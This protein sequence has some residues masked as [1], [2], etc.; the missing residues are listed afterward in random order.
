MHEARP[1]FYQKTRRPIR[2]SHPRVLRST[3]V[4]SH[5]L[6]WPF[7]RESKNTIPRARLRGTAIFTPVYLPQRFGQSRAALIGQRRLA[8]SLQARRRIRSASQPGESRS[9]YRLE[10][11][12][13]AVH[14]YIA[15]ALQ[16]L[17]TSSATSTA[18]A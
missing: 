8:Q 12:Q 18:S 10:I 17:R 4:I 2:T 13:S 15:V 9:H 1:S 14:V 6:G 7:S 3:T 5:D 11:P 16:Q